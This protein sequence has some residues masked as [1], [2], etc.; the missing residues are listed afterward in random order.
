MSDFA[1]SRLN[2]VESQIR[3]SDITDRRIIRAMLA[4][5]REEFVPQRSKPVCYMDQDLLLPAS[6]PGQ[7]HRFLLAPRSQA[8]L[9]Q[10]LELD[11]TKTVLDLACASGYST[12]LLSSLAKQVIAVEADEEVGEVAQE[13]LKRLAISNAQLRIAPLVDGAPDDGPYDAILINGAVDFVPNSLLD[14]LKDGGRLIGVLAAPGIGRATEWVRTGSRVGQ[15]AMFD[16]TAPKLP[17]F[18]KAVGF[19]F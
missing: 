5:P 6:E 17:E 4:L 10:A 13:M 2:M 1:V 11:E 8:K 9:A 19:V 7:A 14:Q 18:S 12:A 3:P 15:A 16:L